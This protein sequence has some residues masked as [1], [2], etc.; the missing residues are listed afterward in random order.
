MSGLFDEFPPLSR[1]DW[2]AQL[3]GR[4]GFDGKPIY[5]SEDVAGIEPRELYSSNGWKI[6]CEVADPASARDA[7]SR[8]ASVLYVEGNLDLSGVPLDGIEVVRSAGLPIAPGQYSAVQ[9]LT[10]LMSQNVTPMIELPVGPEYF[11]E[12]AK[13]RAARLLC[14]NSRFVAHT[15][16]RN[17]AIYDPYVNLLRGTTEA[18]SAI[19][20]GCDIL[21]VRPFDAVY[22]NPGEFSRRLAINTQLLLREESY[23][24]RM[25]D[26]AAGCWYL[27]WLT[28]QLIEKAKRGDPGEPER[29]KI[30]VGVNRYPD[31]DDRALSRLNIKPDE[32]RDP[33]A[34]EKARL[35]AERQ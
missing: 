34:F 3:S 15:T 8:G 27:E 5:T 12:I 30:F 23:F 31:P 11:I 1:A 29:E 24:D 14:P 6:G 18:M 16:K 9:Q 17:L 20:G 32:D 7:I 33:W 13:F 21:I 26:P 35:D 22:Q 28:G 25:Q 4:G 10:W 2:E 19:I